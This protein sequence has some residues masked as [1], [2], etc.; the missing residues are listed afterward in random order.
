MVMLISTPAS[1]HLHLYESPR[2]SLGLPTQLKEECKIV[3][4]EGEGFPSF[5]HRPLTQGAQESLNLPLMLD[6]GGLRL[7]G[8]EQLRMRWS[9]CVYV[10]VCGWGYKE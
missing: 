3:H 2:S 10:F 8:L 9:V 6:E 5:L 1:A 4:L 7:K